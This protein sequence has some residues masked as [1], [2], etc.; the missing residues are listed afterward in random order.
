MLG[1]SLKPDGTAPQDLKDRALAAKALLDEG[2]VNKIIVCGSDPAGVGHTEASEAAQVL[3]SAG[4]SAESIIMEAQSTT[5][6][7]NAWFALR[8]IP[9]GTGQLYLVTSDFHMARATYIFAEVFNYF[10]KMVEEHYVHD[11]AWIS[12]AKRYPRLAIHQVPA[13]SFCG[14]D[15]S[16]S[17]DGDPNADVNEW[18]LAKR[19][20]DE[21]GF[22]G[23]NEV[24]ASLYGE[25]LAPIMY[26]W[27]IQIDVNKD[28][29]GQGNWRKAMAQAMHV[30]QSLCVC[31]ARPQP[32]GAE[33]LP[34][35]LQTPIP[36]SFPEGF[37]AKSWRG[38]INTCKAR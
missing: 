29:E 7:E 28:P 6:G 34:Y 9:Q 30:A 13:R 26:I 32:G 12:A 21:L 3:T 15:A 35:P 11:P 27:P 33:V 22:L 24:S 18:S 2:K 10:Y 1:Q 19:A 36:D 4:V 17:K 31:Q 38:I 14:S 25:P 5:T 23:R 37:S 16:L 8:W 20:L